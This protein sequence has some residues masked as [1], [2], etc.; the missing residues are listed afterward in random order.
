M[1]KAIVIPDASFASFN[2]GTVTPLEDTTIKGLRIIAPETFTGYTLQLS[3]EYRPT[4][5]TQKGVTWSIESGSEYATISQTG[6]LGIKPGSDGDTVTV[7]AV[8]NYNSTIY[9]TVDIDVT[10]I[11]PTYDV[12]PDNVKLTFGSSDLKAQYYHAPND[13]QANNR[14]RMLYS[15]NGSVTINS[16]PLDSGGA[17]RS[18][19]VTDSMYLIDVPYDAVSVTL[20]GQN[21]YFNTRNIRVS[22]ID[23]SQIRLTEDTISSVPST[24]TVPSGAKYLY[25]RINVAQKGDTYVVPTITWNYE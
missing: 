16:L 2:L 13:T 15:D 20:T 6:L 3:L 14:E 8:S 25:V 17:G 22:F 9:D 19:L 7:K 21:L 10:R 12:V 4:M 5:T 24:V 18:N 11:E 23:A 1:G